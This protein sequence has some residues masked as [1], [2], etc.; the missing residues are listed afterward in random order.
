MKV[1][2][3]KLL[4]FICFISS[5]ATF[6]AMFP[7]EEEEISFDQEDESF[8]TAQI[9]NLQDKAGKTLL[10]YAIE[11]KN[12]FLVSQ[13]LEKE[14]NPNALTHGKTPLMLAVEMNLLEIVNTL[15]L[16]GAKDPDHYDLFTTAIRNRASQIIHSL[17]RAGF[18]I[19]ARSADDS[20]PLID[21]IQFKDGDI[22]D[23][24]LS[25]GADHTLRDGDNRSVYDVVQKMQKPIAGGSPFSIEHLRDTGDSI[26][27]PGA[28]SKITCKEIVD[29]LQK[30][31]SFQIT[32]ARAK[33]IA[34]RLASM[35]IDDAIQFFVKNIDKS[36]HKEVLFFV[37]PY[38]HDRLKPH[39][40]KRTPIDEQPDQNS[41]GCLIQ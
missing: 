22:I 14:A 20:F 23:T 29:R 9:L 32:I 37:P 26:I 13:I 15:L 8:P 31:E 4:F 7:L 39:A 21:A 11:T 10:G 19:N 36:F 34:Q 30:A 16:F 17:V 1:R 33:E 38:L 24:C 35:P 5:S 6:F 27:E 18:D 40:L 3:L 12:A 25:L 28:M 41:A 2:T